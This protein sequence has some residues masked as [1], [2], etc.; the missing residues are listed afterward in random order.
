MIEVASFPDLRAYYASVGEVTTSERIIAQL[1]PF[2][3]PPELRALSRPNL[4][5]AFARLKT[6]DIQRRL[7]L[8]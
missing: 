5:E 4:V 3:N 7:G 6:A 2:A 1:A 8:R